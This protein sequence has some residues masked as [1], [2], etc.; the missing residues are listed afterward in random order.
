MKV[1]EARIAAHVC[2]DG[3]LS[4]YLDKNALQIV[5]GR[6]YHRPRRRYVIGYSNTDLGLLKE[7]KKD[8]K[9]IYGIKALSGHK[10]DLRARSK[11]VFKRLETLGAGSSYQWF[12]GK[13]ILNSSKNVKRNWL[14]AF[15]DD[16]ATVA[17]KEK[18]IRVK[19]MNGKGLKQVKSLLK[20]F[21]I[22]SKITGPNSDNSWYLTIN[23]LAV[24]KF[25][26]SIGLK[27][28]KRLQSLRHLVKLL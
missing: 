19:S 27:Q 8:V 22:K 2:A 20:T 28:K 26:L 21:L 16:E 24:K 6:R 11:R 14:R 10:S 13:E 23:Y 17:I 7:F 12:I 1:E 18:R 15:F 5:H 4:I 9:K 25:Y 3:W